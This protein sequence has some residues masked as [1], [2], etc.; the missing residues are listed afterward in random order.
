MAKQVNSK[1]L[2]NI[3]CFVNGTWEVRR[4]DEPDDRVRWD[5]Q[6]QYDQLVR[7]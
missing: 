4:I 1:A 6:L 2:R 3:G 5:N 7:S